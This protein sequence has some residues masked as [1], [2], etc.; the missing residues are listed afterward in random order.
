M[1]NQVYL[2]RLS[3]S[4]MH[5]NIGESTY[6]VSKRLK[7]AVTLS[8]TGTESILTVEYFPPINLATDYV[9][10]LINFQTFN[11]IPNIDQKNNLLHFGNL[12][13][14][15]PVG[16][17]EIDDIN[18]YVKDYLKINNHQNKAFLLKANNNT[19]KS[20]IFSSESIDFDQDNSIGSVLGFQREK[21]KPHYLHKSSLPVN[22]VKVNSIQ[23][24]CNIVSGSFLNNKSVHTIHAFSPNVPP[25]Y[26][27]NEVPRHVAY[28]PINSR[29]ITSL[30]L[31]ITDQNGDL[32]NF[33][34]EEITIRLHLIPRH[35][36][37]Q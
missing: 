19:L 20:E 33:R 3:L 26:K 18:E 12:I 1:N 10:G 13:I 15:I 11:S 35:V 6:Q 32:V 34:G 4:R 30:T 17:Y 5:I 28:L 37:V 23:I 36:G 22:I 7:M 25:G 27:I 24:E 8:V 21:L 9:C 14:K 16:S 2:S 29:R 31:K